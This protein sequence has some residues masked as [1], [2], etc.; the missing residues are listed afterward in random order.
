MWGLEKKDTW[1]WPS[2]NEVSL[3]HGFPVVMQ[4]L[5]QAVRDCSP[6]TVQHVDEPGFTGSNKGIGTDRKGLIST[7]F[8]FE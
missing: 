8:A 7:D 5:E 6:M 2:K 4:R 3:K 1:A